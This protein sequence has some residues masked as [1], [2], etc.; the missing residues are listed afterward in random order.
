MTFSIPILITG[1]AKNKI[2]TSIGREIYRVL[3]MIWHW[4]ILRALDYAQLIDGARWGLKAI[5]RFRDKLA[6]LR[7]RSDA[8]KQVS[9]D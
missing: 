8:S 7:V 9:F 4:I 3:G 6:T 5:D 1:N 2:M